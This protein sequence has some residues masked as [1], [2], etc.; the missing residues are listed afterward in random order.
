MVLIFGEDASQVDM[1]VY[2]LRD[3]GEVVRGAYDVRTLRYALQ[4]GKTQAITVRVLPSR[5]EIYASEFTLHKLPARAVDEV[6]ADL[7]S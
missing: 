3:C 7:G 6:M 5:W 1:E 4:E 2:R